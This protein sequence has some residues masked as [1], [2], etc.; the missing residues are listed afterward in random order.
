MNFFYKTS[1]AGRTRGIISHVT[2]SHFTA[3]D[4]RTVCASHAT[5]HSDINHLFVKYII[6]YFGKERKLYSVKYMPRCFI[7]K[8][9]Y[10]TIVLI[11]YIINIHV[12][13]MVM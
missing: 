3:S 4:G 13:I 11:S 6:I 8:I 10:L 1:T 5:H 12:H 9:K 7:E 2:Q